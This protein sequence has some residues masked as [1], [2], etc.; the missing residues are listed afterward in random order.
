MQSQGHSE[1]NFL[2]R[3]I[4]FGSKQKIS[5]KP[6]KFITRTQKKKHIRN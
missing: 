3:R 6:N 5:I 2:F 4:H 1:I